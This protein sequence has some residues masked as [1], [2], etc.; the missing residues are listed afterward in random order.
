[1]YKQTQEMKNKDILIKRAR[2]ILMK[3]ITYNAQINK[4]TATPDEFYKVMIE[5][6]KYV[7]E[8]QK[9]QCYNDLV[10][11]SDTIKE[12]VLNSETVV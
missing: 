3:N 4:F 11:E 5:F 12:K 7:A 8:A 1:M 10:D 6:S 9:M 2:D